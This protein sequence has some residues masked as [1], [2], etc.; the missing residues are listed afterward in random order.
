MSLIETLQNY[1][2][3][4]FDD[5]TKEDHQESRHEINFGKT[6]A[7]GFPGVDNEQ[8]I[9]FQFAIGGRTTKWRAYGYI[10]SPMFYLVWLDTEHALYKN[11]G[12]A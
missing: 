12:E 1:E 4:A 9:P 10:S 6:I 8:Q 7:D 3:W 2:S 11:K 5:F